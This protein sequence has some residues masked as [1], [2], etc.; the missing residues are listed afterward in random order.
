[1]AA[2]VSVIAL[3]ALATALGILY[4]AGTGR[5]RRTRT[6]DRVAIAGVDL[7]ERATLLQFSSEV[8]APCRATARVLGEF[9]HDGVRH[10]EVDVAQRRDLADR[11]GILQTP[12]TLLIDGEGRV[13]SRIGG[14]PRRAT[15]VAELDEVL[16]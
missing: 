6:E 12:T 9:A 8:C 16:A 11:F 2:L 14:A 1:M 13:R 3:V 4:S 15:V 7:G 10:V 5:A